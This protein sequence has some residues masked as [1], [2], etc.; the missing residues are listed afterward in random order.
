MAA[1]AP[2]TEE[3]LSEL[4]HQKYGLSKEKIKR[5][6][7]GGKSY[8]Q[9]SSLINHCVHSLYRTLTDS[10]GDSRWPNNAI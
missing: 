7:A 4:E 2:F 6:D 10:S 3:N 5:Q 1:K 9:I 8:L